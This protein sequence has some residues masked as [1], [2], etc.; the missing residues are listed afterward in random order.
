[1][2]LHF[3]GDAAEST[4]VAFKRERADL[5]QSLGG[6]GRMAC[7]ERYAFHASTR[8]TRSYL[9]APGVRSGEATQRVGPFRAAPGTAGRANA[10]VAR[11]RDFA[12]PAWTG[13]SLLALVWRGSGER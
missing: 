9:G 13:D 6:R 5:G 2:V 7:A 8:R 3:F 11:R 1:M 12:V 10:A 4:N